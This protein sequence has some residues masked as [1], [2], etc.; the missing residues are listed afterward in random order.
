MLPD[1]L[2]PGIPPLNVGRPCWA[3]A[4]VIGPGLV[5]LKVAPIGG[6]PPPAGELRVAPADCALLNAEF[7]C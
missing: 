5:V 3:V 1:I 4:Q 2:P 6:K 7:N